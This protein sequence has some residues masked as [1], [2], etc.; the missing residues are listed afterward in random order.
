MPNPTGVPAFGAY[1]TERVG[2]NTE[3]FHAWWAD[4]SIATW[5]E[6]AG[7]WERGESPDFAALFPERVTRD[8]NAMTEREAWESLAVLVARFP[9]RF[10]EGLCAEL[11]RRVDGLRGVVPK[12]S[13]VHAMYERIKKHADMARDGH[14]GYLY[15]P[16]DPKGGSASAHARVIFC[17]LMAL[18]CEDEARGR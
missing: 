4:G 6:D 3:I 16:Y 7:R 15:S 14:G 11:S 9:Y 1:F 8:V 12:Y 10:R 13:Q 2:V 17:L 18:E 5:D